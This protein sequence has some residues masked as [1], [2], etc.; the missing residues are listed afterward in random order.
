[1]PAKDEEPLEE[2]DDCGRV[3]GTDTKYLATAGGWPGQVTK[4][5]A[6]AGWGQTQIH[7]T[8]ARVAGT[9]HQVSCDCGRGQTQIHSTAAA[10]HVLRM[11]RVL[12]MTM[13]SPGTAEYLTHAC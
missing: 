13:V 2:L 3:A 7:S 8:A 6:T 10:R 5:L 12:R 4:Y 1:M 9:G 11:A